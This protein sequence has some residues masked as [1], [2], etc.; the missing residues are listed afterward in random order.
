[1]AI[2]PIFSSFVATIPDRLAQVGDDF[3]DQYLIGD[4]G[5]IIQVKAAVR[6]NSADWTEVQVSLSATADDIVVENTGYAYTPDLHVAT[7]VA[8]LGIN[9]SHRALVDLKF[10]VEG[11]AADPSFPASAQ[12]SNIVVTGILQAGEL[13]VVSH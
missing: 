3:R 11:K 9:V 5:W 10:S 1:M 12:I 7:V 4:G 6:D 8:V 13:T 2:V